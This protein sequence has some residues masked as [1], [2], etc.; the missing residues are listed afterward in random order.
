[1][2]SAPIPENETDRLHALF[3]YHV[4]DTDPE[5]A[6]DQLT[7]LASSV[8]KTPIALV[9]LIDE[10][11]QWFKSHHGL[12]ASETPRE[13][14][15]CAHAIHQTAIFE[16]EDSRKDERFSDNPL[17]TEEP[18][19]IFYAGAPLETPEGHRI[20]TLCVIDHEPSQLNDLQKQQL[21]IIAKQ[22]VTQ[23]ELRKSS[24]A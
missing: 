15:F 13:L 18:H 10:K 22:V 8:C 5:A 14:A 9:S 3:S 17:V 11:R 2:Q 23:L 4:L 16:I 19:V 20:G 12:D 21:S 24:H 1:L 7:Q 6:F